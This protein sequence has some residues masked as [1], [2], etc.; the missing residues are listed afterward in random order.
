MSSYALAP[1]TLAHRIG[2]WAA[3]LCA[4]HCLLWPTL[5][6]ALAL[7]GLADI[8]YVDIVMAGVSLVA[9]ALVLPRERASVQVAFVALWVALAV[10]I[11][12][13]MGHSHWGG[14]VTVAASLGLALTHLLVLN[15]RRRER[16]GC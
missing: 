2:G 11:V 6:L 12:A 5:V 8:P 3:F 9:L 13:E 4:V 14:A 15:A 1:D 7:G 16:T 10:G